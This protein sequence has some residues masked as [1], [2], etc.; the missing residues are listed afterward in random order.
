[1]PFAAFGCPPDLPLSSFAMNRLQSFS[2]FGW[3]GWQSRR[4]AAGWDWA[5]G[6]KAN[7][8][9]TPHFRSDARDPLI[10][11]QEKTGDAWKGCARPASASSRAKVFR[12]RP[13]GPSPRAT[14]VGTL[15]ARNPEAYL[16]AGGGQIFGWSQSIRLRLPRFSLNC[17]HRLIDHPEQ[18]LRPCSVVAEQVK[19]AGNCSNHPAM[20]AVNAAMFACTVAGVSLSVLV[21]TRTNG[22]ALRASHSTNSTSISC[23]CKPGINQRKDQAKIRAML[24]IIDTA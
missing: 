19:I 17:R 24:E 21:K 12:G 3:P 20:R 6:G 15:F 14:Q 7:G 10:A 4:Y 5:F 2:L 11:T 22:T 9:F 23:G 8:R 1:M 16:L 13:Q 18:L